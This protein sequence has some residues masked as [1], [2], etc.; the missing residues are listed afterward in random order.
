MSER[1]QEAALAAAQL[2]G[3]V[4][5]GIVLYQMGQ[6]EVG[7]LVIGAALGHAAP[8]RARGGGGVPPVAPLLMLLGAIALG[9]LS[10]CDG[11]PDAARRSVEVATVVLLDADRDAAV[12]YTAAA[13][14]AIERS[15]TLAEYRAAMSPHD[16]LEQALR[17][18]QST[19]LAADAALDAWRAGGAERWPQ[20]A[21]CVVVALA[22]LRSAL[23]AVGLPTPPEL[24]AV[25]TTARSFALDACEGEA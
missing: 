2:L 15:T 12:R 1:M 11:P 10:G 5:A 21:A 6:T 9:A 19:I 18:S 22:D 3:L 4:I 24:D 25:I 7:S 8:R 23:A 16:A 20:L 14:A 17:V 13:E